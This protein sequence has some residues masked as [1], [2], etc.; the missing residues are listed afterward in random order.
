[1]Y[2]SVGQYSVFDNH[3]TAFSRISGSP[4]YIT[5]GAQVGG[6]FV[7]HT[8]G[9][10]NRIRAYSEYQPVEDV[11]VAGTGDPHLDG[12]GQFYRAVPWG[13]SVE[14]FILDD[15]SYRDAVRMTMPRR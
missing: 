6:Q 9:F 10:R 3:E 7:N 14:V 4:P 12:T 15:R 13:G 11:T 2:A 8:E 1:M 5:G